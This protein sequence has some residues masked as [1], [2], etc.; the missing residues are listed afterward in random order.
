M[1]ISTDCAAS[2]AGQKESCGNAQPEAVTHHA[3]GEIPL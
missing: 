1:C 2:D 3:V